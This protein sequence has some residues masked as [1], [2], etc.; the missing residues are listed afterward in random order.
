MS[1]SLYLW[2]WAILVLGKWTIGATSVTLPL[3]LLLS[4][5]AAAFSYVYIEKPLRY[6]QWSRSNA[7]TI[8]YGV[9]ATLVTMVAIN[10]M[11]MGLRQSYNDTLPGML[12]VPLI[13]EWKDLQCNGRKNVQKLAKPFES[14]LHASRSDAKPHAVYVVGDSHASQLTPMVKSA[15]QD[16]PFQVLFMNPESST[17]F[18]QVFLFSTGAKAPSLEYVLNDSQPGDIVLLTFHRGRFHE[19]RDSHIPLDERIGANERT[20]AMT[21]NLASYLETLVA[22]GIKTVLVKDTPLMSVRATSATCLLQIKLTGASVCRVS[23]AQDLHTRKRQDVVFDALAGRSRMIV[24]WDP[25]PFMYMDRKV[26]DVVDGGGRYLMADWN[27]IS[28]FQSELLAPEFRRFI[29]QEVL[30]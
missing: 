18:P 6:A 30:N 27:H 25:L 3:L 14:C 13:E 29:E 16:M 26:F 12:G 7:R 20:E 15:F 19:E 8:G 17:D 5:G 10:S 4:L 11:F 24:T 2:H 28:V 21:S 9:V 1:Y 23:R 22:R